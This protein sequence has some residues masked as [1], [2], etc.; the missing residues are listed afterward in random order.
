MGM[1]RPAST[2]EIAAAVEGLLAERG[3]LS[4]E[5]LLAALAGSGVEPGGNPGA[6]LADVLESDDLPSVLPLLDGRYAFLPALLAGRVF[7]HRVTEAEVE[8]GFVAVSPDL[9]PL[10]LVV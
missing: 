10:S 6:M 1:G 8:Y 3:P 5:E 9:E 7:T 4:E 2:V